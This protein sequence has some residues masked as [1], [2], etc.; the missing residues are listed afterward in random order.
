MKMSYSEHVDGDYEEEFILR[1][2]IWSAIEKNSLVE[3]EKLE[4]KAIIGSSLVEETLDLHEEVAY[5]QQIDYCL[6]QIIN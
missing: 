1:E 3:E 5:S 6:G 4:I 2:P